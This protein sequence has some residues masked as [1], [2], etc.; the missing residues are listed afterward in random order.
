MIFELSYGIIEKMMWNPK[1]EFE[2]LK[3][4]D[5]C[6]WFKR[7]LNYKKKLYRLNVVEYN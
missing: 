5:H 2:V 1:S 4:C 3:N 7:Q 6:T